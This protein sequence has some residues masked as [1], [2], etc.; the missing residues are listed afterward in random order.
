MAKAKIGIKYCGGCN[1]TYERVEMI[2]VVQSLAKKRFLFLGHDQQDLD[3]VIA[4]N[5]CPR[6]C[7]VKDLKPGEA[8]YYSIAGK[9]DL[10]SLLEWL[11]ILEQNENK[12]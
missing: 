4:V 2:Q 6:V 1:P 11:F 3:G 12:R 5:G 8:P 10:N 9:G 7:A